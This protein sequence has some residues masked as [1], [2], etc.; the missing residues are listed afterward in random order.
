MSPAT[1]SRTEAL[2]K[3]RLEWRLLLQFDS[4]DDLGIMWGDCGM[5]YFWIRESDIQAKLFNESWTILQCS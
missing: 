1:M 4:D 5:I 2:P 3:G